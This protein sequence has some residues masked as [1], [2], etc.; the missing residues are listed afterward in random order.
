MRRFALTLGLFFASLTRLCR[1]WWLALAA[2]FGARRLLCAFAVFLVSSAVVIAVENTGSAVAD[3]VCAS[4]ASDPDGDGFGWENDASCIVAS[5]SDGSGDD[6]ADADSQQIEQAALSEPSSESDAQGRVICQDPS[7]DP[8]GDGFGWEAGESCISQADNSTDPTPEPSV[9]EPSET[10]APAVATSNGPVPSCSAAAAD[11]GDG[12]GWENNQSCKMVAAKLSQS[13]Q[14]RA[15]LERLD[16]GLL[17]ALQRQVDAVEN[18]VNVAVSTN[19]DRGSIERQWLAVGTELAPLTMCREQVDA[20]GVTFA[21]AVAQSFANGGQSVGE[22]VA[23]QL[24]EMVNSIDGQGLIGVERSGCPQPQS[25]EADLAENQLPESELSETEL[26]QAKQDPA[27]ATKVSPP[28]EEAAETEPTVVELAQAETSEPGL[29]SEQD[30]V[31]IP[32]PATAAASQTESVR[33][34][35]SVNAVDNGDGWGWENDQSCKMVSPGEAGTSSQAVVVP[36]GD[37]ATQAQDP[38]PKLPDTQPTETAISET[39][40]LETQQDPAVVPQAATTTSTLQTVAERPACS[41]NA[42]DNGDGWGWENDQSC[43]MALPE[44][45][46]TSDPTAVAAQVGGTVVVDSAT[47]ANNGEAADASAS[48]NPQQGSGSVQVDVFKADV[49]G[50]LSGEKVTFYVPLLNS[51]AGLVGLADTYPGDAAGLA[52]EIDLIRAQLENAFGPYTACRDQRSALAEL[53]I[54]QVTGFP[55]TATLGSRMADQFVFLVGNVSELGFFAYASCSQQLIDVAPP[56]PGITVP[57]PEGGRR[58]S[59][60][61]FDDDGDGIGI[62]NGRTCTVNSFTVTQVDSV[63]CEP[64]TARTSK[65]VREGRDEYTV[66]VAATVGSGVSSINDACFSQS[67]PGYTPYSLDGTLGFTGGAID[68]N[69][70]AANLDANIQ[71]ARVFQATR[72]LA[73][74][75]SLRQLERLTLKVA[76]GKLGLDP[77][78][79][80]NHAGLYQLRTLV[81]EGTLNNAPT[82]CSRGN[83][84]GCDPPPPSPSERLWANAS[85]AERLQY[86]GLTEARWNYAAESIELAKTIGSR[87]SSGVQKFAKLAIAV[88]FTYVLGQ[89]GVALWQSVFPAVATAP[90]AGAVGS[91]A[92]AAPT[93]AGAIAPTAAATVAAPTASAL[94]F[95]SVFGNYTSTLILTGDSDAAAK[96]IG[97][98]LVTAGLNYLAGLGGDVSKLTVQQKLMHAT[99]KCAQAHLSEPG[100]CAGAATVSLFN[101]FGGGDFLETGYPDFDTYV[102]K[103]LSAI[104]KLLKK[105]DDDWGLVFTELGIIGVGELLDVPY[106]T[107]DAFDG[108]EEGIVSSVSDLLITAAVIGD[109]PEESPELKKYFFKETLPNLSQGVDKAVTKELGG[110]NNFWPRFAGDLS[111]MAIRQAADPNYDAEAAL[112]TYV[113]QQVGAK[114]LRASVAQM[115]TEPA[116]PPWAI[117]YLSEAAT[118]LEMT[119]ANFGARNE[120]LYNLTLAAGEIGILGGTQKCRDAQ[121]R[122][123][124]ESVS[125][126][127]VRNS[128]FPKPDTVAFD[129]TVGVFTVYVQGIQASGDVCKT[130]AIRAVAREQQRLKDEDGGK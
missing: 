129:R 14:F 67:A 35:C 70:V 28:Q 104:P 125:K 24:I 93:A 7:S 92:I 29:S 44:A 112:E 68:Q 91:T 66:P 96:T 13:E 53:L 87:Q 73:S 74:N 100:T 117:N 130:E 111:G 51:V 89:V 72:S 12:W 128:G 95:G 57:L 79:Y 45:V 5:E 109:N 21:D 69:S 20:L 40:L 31:P 121:L 102:R 49:L 61:A 114:A 113:Y 41:A 48:P 82:Y 116:T 36:A 108:S 94:A 78:Q 123:F 58:C 3:P 4:A 85:V 110:W 118:I 88:A 55:T 37:A 76:F 120:A 65:V 90:T 126:N 34:I 50:S 16:P 54:Q 30:P 71:A 15:R 124:R 26:P 107:T 83:D 9:E 106:L 46:D 52:A 47:T 1:L 6:V 11:N 119:G 59:S 32:E 19:G 81:N 75:S 62:E 97:P 101:S 115:K 80:T 63:T 42:V 127:I 8:D 105:Y 27:T 86:L 18:F 25:V 98:S 38:Q 2:R 10:E 84:E 43:R 64:G 17:T 99:L 56:A 60:A 103:A 33:P 23:D 39:E 22:D 122:K 77:D